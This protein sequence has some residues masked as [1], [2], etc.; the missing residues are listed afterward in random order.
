M[1]HNK[2]QFEGYKG[3]R[4][5]LVACKPSHAP[6]FRKKDQDEE[7]YIRAGGSSAKLTL[8]Q[9]NDYRR[10]RFI[11]LAFGDGLFEG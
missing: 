9:M 1:L 3:K 2:P 11:S 10:Q 5:M 8:S 6:I 4:I 7:F